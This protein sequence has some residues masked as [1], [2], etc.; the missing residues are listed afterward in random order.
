M[1]S[2]VDGAERSDAPATEY[3]HSQP[4]R[5]RVASSHGSVVRCGITKAVP[6]WTYL[7]VS[8]AI[9]PPLTSG[10]EIVRGRGLLGRDHALQI[11]DGGWNT[12]NLTPAS[13]S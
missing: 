5:S 4:S 2:H 13:H 7:L 6:L 10:I 1:A 11:R 3:E 12:E 8:A 9:S